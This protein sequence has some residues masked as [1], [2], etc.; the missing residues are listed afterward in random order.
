M[1]YKKSNGDSNNQN[2][3]SAPDEYESRE[4]WKR[5][6]GIKKVHNKHVERL[7]NIKS[8]LLDREEVIT[9]PKKYLQKILQKLPHQK[10][11]GKDEL[12]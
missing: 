7:S 12:Q 8:E 4:S 9:I 2:T 10:V 11:F 5:K 3:S 6:W 1:F